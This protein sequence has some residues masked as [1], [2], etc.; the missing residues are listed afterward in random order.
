MEVYI[1]NVMQQQGVSTKQLAERLK[2]SPQYVSNIV[3]GGKNLSM[4]TLQEVANALG[5]PTWRLLAPDGVGERTTDG[6][7]QVCPH[8]GKPI[9]VKIE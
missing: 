4:N 8:C 1:K 6:L 5:V 7:A 9:T 2:K 3:N